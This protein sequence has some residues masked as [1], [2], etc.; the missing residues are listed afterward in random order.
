MGRVSLKSA[1]KRYI[2][3]MQK[4]EVNVNNVSLLPNQLLQGKSA[5]VTGAGS[6]IGMAISKTYIDSGATVIGL[7]RDINK[8]ND[9]RM[10]LGNRFIPFA[11]DISDVN[12]IEGYLNKIIDLS[13]SGIVDILVN[14]AGTKN[15]NDER[16]F[17]Y[18]EDDFETVV[19]TN[20]K[21]TFFWCQKVSK[22]MIANKIHG[23]IINIASIKGFIGEASPYS[24]SKWGVVGLTKGL[25]RI[26][27]SEG[28]V[29]NG[30]AP[31]GTLTPMAN[32]ADNKMLHL[33]TPNMRLADPNEIANIALF[34][35]SDLG[36]N[37]IG[38]IIISDGG[39]TL[40]YGNNR[41]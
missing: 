26:L 35:G 40:Q 21:G 6:G 16:F 2:K 20:L 1:I 12:K 29:V 39:Q 24:V 4:I 8:L 27:A 18:T 19:N 38:D 31:G 25:G 37:I 14:C 17:E 41:I 33:A 22:Y 13:P 36:N 11:C 30:I 5:I 23:H 15:G 34:L 9:V 28:I 7:G 10:Q 32:I 3:G